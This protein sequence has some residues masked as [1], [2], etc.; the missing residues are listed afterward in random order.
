MSLDLRS[1]QMIPSLYRVFAQENSIPFSVQRRIRGPQVLIFQILLQQTK[2]LKKITNL[3]EELG[4]ALGSDSPRIARNRSL[5]DVEIPLPTQLRTPVTV[6]NLKRKS[7]FW[8]TPGKTATNRPVHLNLT[9]PSCAQW[10]ICGMT[11]SGKTVAMKL[12]AWELV[13]QNNENALQLILIDG[14]GGFN[15]K[16]FDNI[17]H[18][19]NPII[20]KPDEAVAALAWALAE[21]ESRKE[22]GQSSPRIIILVDEIAEVLK[23]AGDKASEAIQ[24]IAALGRELG[25]HL[26]LATQYPKAEVL[27]GKLAEAN[28]GCRLVGRV[29]DASDSAFAC[30]V[31]GAG[32]HLLTGNGDFLVV[33]GG[34]AHRVQIAFINDSDIQPLPRTDSPKT[35]DL[36]EFSLDRLIELT[37]SAKKKGP[38]RPTL[39]LSAKILANAIAVWVRLPLGKKKP[40]YSTFS[41]EAGTSFPRGKEHLQMARNILDEL[42]TLNLEV[43]DN[44][45]NMGS[46]GGNAGM[47][48]LRSTNSPPQI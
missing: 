12:I 45:E 3:G 1:R 48:L 9:G 8:I 18:L 21:M 38:G 31:G 22:T 16:P 39:P 36:K 4:L 5:V 17:P 47:S 42:K 44:E 19:A 7:R 43:I 37:P 24:R 11:G 28:I 30:G 46:Q 29:G 34:E 33:V 10:L 25:V 40:A 2:D 6:G 32:A 41:T 15:W 14:K 26:V 27:G 13:Q 35:I 23:L 20:V